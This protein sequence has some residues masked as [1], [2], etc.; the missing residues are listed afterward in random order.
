MARLAYVGVVGSKSEEGDD[1]DVSLGSTSTTM[2][3]EEE[4]L[5][6]F[7]AAAARDAATSACLDMFVVNRLVRAC[8]LLVLA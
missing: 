2:D 6:D 5:N 3:L 8:L 7:L 4:A 1:D